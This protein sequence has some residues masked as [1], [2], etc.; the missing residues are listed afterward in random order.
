M[1]T[2]LSDTI[3]KAVARMCI[4][5]NYHL[6]ADVLDALGRALDSE[7]SPAG[8]TILQHILKNAQ[9]ANEDVFPL[10]QDTGYAVFFVEVGKD[11][12]ITGSDL[13]TAVHD[14]VRQGYKEGYLRTSIVADPLQREN[15]GDNAPAVVWVDYVP[16]NQLVIQMAPK[17]GGSENMSTVRMLKPAEGCQGVIDT[18]MQ[19]VTDSGGNPCPPGIIGIG[20]GGTFEKCAWLAKKSLLRN[21]D[22]RHP[23]PY[24]A[25]LELEILDRV[26]KTGIGPMGLG[27]S[28]TALDV[29][30]ET[31]P[32]HI[33]S[34]PVAVNIQCHSARHQKVI[35]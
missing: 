12:R 1:R 21:I 18:V 33:A 23:D 24:Y 11:L 32:C 35:L 26:N 4:K 20:I 22:D 6:G 2:L 3:T 28:T 9:I 30:I 34:L 8:R 19:H 15:T 7:K 5:A 16:G 10:C 29:H 17:G 31:Y 13:Q 25:E 27:G 14:G